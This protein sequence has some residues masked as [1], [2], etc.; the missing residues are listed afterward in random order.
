MKR[1]D[2]RHPNLSIVAAVAVVLSLSAAPAP[3]AVLTIYNLGTLGGTESYGGGINASGQ[4]AGSSLTSNFTHH[5]FLYTGMPGKGGVIHDLGTLGGTISGGSA[6]NDAGQVAGH[7]WITGN[8]AHHAFRY[9]GTP[10]SGG[11]MH[12]LGTLGGNFGYSYGFAINDSGQVAGWTEVVVNNMTREHAFLYS[13]TPGSGGV[14]HDLGTLGGPVSYGRGINNNGHVVGFSLTSNS[15][16][17]AFLYTGTPGSGGMMHDLGTLGG[18]FAEGMDVNASGQVAGWSQ[19]ADNVTP[20]AFLYTGM[21]GNGGVMHDLGTL[22]GRGSYA[23]AI[24]ESGQVVGFSDTA[25]GF[26][27]HAFFYTGTPGLD[28]QMIDLDIWLDAN[29]PTEGAKWTLSLAAGLSNTGWITGTGSYDPDGPGGVAEADRAFLLDASSLVP[30]PAG[31]A[32]LGLALP[33]LLHRRRRKRLGVLRDVGE[34]KF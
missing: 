11:M 32:L 19:L 34:K 1:R 17:H 6:I 16:Q 27:Q 26:S 33:A 2:F 30:E 3:A 28:G 9:D 22:G 21:P 10:G 25:G 24:S 15:T 29:N 31:I 8:G 5:A 14:M 18:T 20:H 7:S 13:G 4:V 12:D 23:H